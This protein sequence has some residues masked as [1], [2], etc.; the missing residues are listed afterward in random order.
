LEEAARC[1]TRAQSRAQVVEQKSL[2][3]EWETEMEGEIYSS[4]RGRHPRMQ[5]QTPSLQDG[6]WVAQVNGSFPRSHFILKE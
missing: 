5:S 2:K 1:M 4:E 3:R 6:S